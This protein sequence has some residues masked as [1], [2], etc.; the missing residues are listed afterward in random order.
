MKRLYLLLSRMVAEPRSWF[1]AVA[2]RNRL[3]AEM[4]AELASHLADLTA[5]LIRSGYSA[6]E[7]SRRARIALGS[8]VVHKEAMRA[9]LGLRLSDELGGDLPYALRRLRRSLG[10]T[11]M[12]VISLALAIGANTTIFSMARQI[13]YERLAVERPSEL[14]LLAW[15]GTKKHV[16]V[17]SIWGDYDPVG[18]GRVTST[19]FSYPVYQQLRA[20]N[21]V[22][23]KLFAF[24]GMSGNATI[25]GQAQQAEGE[26]VS[27]N[28]Y[29]QLGVRPVLGRV[30][31]EVDDV[32]T[33]NGAVVVISYGLWQREF[34]GSPTVLGQIIKLNE[35]PLTIIGVNPKGFTG[36]RST[37]GSPQLFAPLAMQPLLRPNGDRGSLLSDNREWWVN[38]IGRIRPGVS[39]ATAQ[40]AL[41]A[42]L[43]AAARATLPVHPDEDLPRM[44]LH[45]GS[46]GLFRQGRSFLQ[47]MRVLLTMV[48]FVLVLSC[49]NIA[50]LML[51]RG[52][53]RQR[54]I[55][56]RLAMGAGRRRIARQM[57]VESLVLAALGGAG[58]AVLG[59]AGTIVAP[60]L[61]HMGWSSDDPRVHFDW[62]VLLF[63]VAITI[64]TGILFG[65]APAFAAA[66]A[67]VSAGLKESS[68][69]V[70]RR[71][72]S[73]GG[74]SLVAFQIALST[75]LVIGAGLFLRTLVGLN[76]VNVGFRTDHLLLA[77]ISLPPKQYPAGKD[78]EFHTQLQQAIAA[79][80]GVEDVSPAAVAYIANST[81]R[82]TFLPEGVTAIKGNDDAEYYNIVGTS[83]FRMMG[84]PILEGRSFGPQDTS[85]SVKVGIINASLARERFPNQNPV[86]RRFHG[87][88]H[89]LIQIVGVCADTHYAS[90]RDEPPP[91]FFVPFVQ[92]QSA[93]GTWTYEIRTGGEPDAAIPALRRVVQRLDPDLPLINVRTQEQQI[94]SATEQERVFVTLTSGFGLLALA[95]ASVGVYGV[96]AY[97]VAQRT[98]EIGIRLA[99]GALPGQVR[100]MILR[101]STGLAGIGVVAGAVAALVLCRLLRSMLYGIRPDDPVTMA[102]GISILLAVALA[103][104]WIPARRAAGVE[105]VEALRH[106]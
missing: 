37:M 66:R 25:A 7:A 18:D 31:S 82:T 47:P 46:R 33:A 42:E 93:N 52:T 1:R 32:S 30:I 96:M 9:S 55:S 19:S 98:N 21:Q 92:Q 67:G 13:L 83:F 48:G 86:G 100:G 29:S 81:N 34:G 50:N 65:L 43:G 11:A 53:Q 63:T 74:R 8:T 97:S 90:L 106:E 62:K 45:D 35:V 75:L 99:L 57:L 12:A 78:V 71:R 105:P 85:T 14:R 73:W 69:S 95:L 5:D 104:S 70:T 87:E 56:V 54:E 10:F 28:Y 61:T 17:H 24:K 44:D 36:A 84:I 91:Q 76:A 26:L 94:L 80:P 72:K 51:A 2:Q 22:M 3:E 16:A 49:A 64:A 6:A 103:A 4:E 88:K 59:Y 77:E 58:G 39:D 68:Q 20:Q 79:V 40:A 38:V 101:E 41:D 23:E 102:A 60:R 15:T 27:G 89:T